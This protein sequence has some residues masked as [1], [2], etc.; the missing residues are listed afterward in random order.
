MR[1]KNLSGRMN[2]SIY[3]P[4][5]TMGELPYEDRQGVVRKYLPESVVHT[6]KVE[7]T[8]ELPHWSA[9]SIAETL[10]LSPTAYEQQC[11]LT[12]EAPVERPKKQKLIACSHE[13][14]LFSAEQYKRVIDYCILYLKPH[15]DEFDAIAV[16][17]YSM[18]LV[19]PT[20]ALI[21]GKNLVLVRKSAEP[22]HSDYTFE[23][24]TDQRV[25][26]VDDLVASGT[27]FLYVKKY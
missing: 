2:I 16:S 13:A 20:I 1:D 21:L 18:A 17:G 6:I 14:Q 26:F 8:K 7:E 19:A 9:V 27:T 25:V 22:R 12:E 23:G 5:L 10:Q 4:F 24:W 3:S 11:A 15:I